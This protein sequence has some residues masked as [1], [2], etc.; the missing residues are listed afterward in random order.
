M[1]KKDSI[2]NFLGDMKIMDDA[3][4][5]KALKSLVSKGLVKEEMINGE[6]HY[7]LTYFGKIV[8]AHGNSAPSTRN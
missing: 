3:S 5:H 6:P 2:D 7:S 1:A 4:V 8:V